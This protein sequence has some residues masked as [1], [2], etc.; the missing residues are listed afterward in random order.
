MSLVKNT[1]YIGAGFENKM[2]TLRQY[3]QFE[4]T[5]GNIGE[6]DRY[7]K[8][9]STNYDEAYV[10]AV[11]YA[12]EDN[13]TLVASLI[14]ELDPIIRQK[15]LIEL[16]DYTCMQRGEAIEKNAKFGHVAIDI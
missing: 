3:I 12:K 8:N 14:D 15:V 11:K 10:K 9:L 2:Y 13:L 4:N 1:Y 5:S 7:I 16:G 6:S